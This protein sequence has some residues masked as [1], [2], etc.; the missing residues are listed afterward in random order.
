MDPATIERL[1]AEYP[2]YYR[3]GKIDSGRPIGRMTPVADAWENAER[4]LED[5]NGPRAAYWAG[6]ANAGEG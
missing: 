2:E 3:G 1:V 4:C 5:E 6:L